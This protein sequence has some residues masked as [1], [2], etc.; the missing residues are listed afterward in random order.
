MKTNH[1]KWEEMW[2]R[3][4]ANYVGWTVN[5]QGSYQSSYLRT[6]DTSYAN[7]GNH[8]GNSKADSYDST[9]NSDNFDHNTDNFKLNSFTS[10]N[11]LENSTVGFQNDPGYFQHDVIQNKSDDT[12]NSYD[13]F[14]P[15]DTYIESIPSEPPCSD[16]S[17]KEAQKTKESV[18]DNSMDVKSADDRS[19]DVESVD[20]GSVDVGSVNDEPDDDKSTE[21]ESVDVKSLDDK[22]SDDESMVEPLKDDVHDVIDAQDENREDSKDDAKNE[23]HNEIT[24]DSKDEEKEEMEEKDEAIDEDISKLEQPDSKA[25]ASVK[26]FSKP[27]NIISEASTGQGFTFTSEKEE[28]KPYLPISFCIPKTLA[29]TAID[30]SNLKKPRTKVTFSCSIYFA[31]KGI[32]GTARLEFLLYS[33]CNFGSESLV[34][35]WSYEISD[36]DECLAQPFKFCFLSQYSFPGRYNYYVRVIP[37]CIKGCCVNIT[38]CQIDVIAQSD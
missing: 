26:T 1:V 9:D 15:V 19:V 33:S 36:K 23:A 34:G 30:T 31:P 3:D 28:V 22:S 7:S 5:S 20:V 14:Y 17:E 32:T 10:E 6:S 4:F 18:K 35:N 11:T 37:V 27:E 12:D 38:N 25:Q 2:E 24:D 13:K 29:I 16:S 21:N 8:D